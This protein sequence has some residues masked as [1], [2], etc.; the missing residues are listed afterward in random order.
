MIGHPC[1]GK[2]HEVGAIA[3]H[4]L[5]IGFYWQVKKQNLIVPN[6]PGLAIQAATARTPTSWTARSSDARSRPIS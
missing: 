5:A 3:L 4:L 2:G 6:V 1:C